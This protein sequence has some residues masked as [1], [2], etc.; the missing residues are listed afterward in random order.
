MI[1]VEIAPGVHESLRAMKD[2]GTPLPRCHKGVIQSAIGGAVRRLVDNT[3]SSGVRPWDVPELE[4]RTAELGELSSARAE[5]VDENVLVGSLLPGGQRI[6]LRGVDDEWR[7]VRFVDGDDVSLRPE[8][9]RRVELRGSAPDCV[10]TALG[11]VKPDRVE[12][13]VVSEYLGGGET[14]TRYRY[15]WTEGSKSILAEEVKNEIFDGATPYSTYVRGVIVD[16]DRGVLLTGR[17]DS[18]LIIEG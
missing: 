12:L 10:V 9:T 11:L 2:R 4:R 6:V 14:E 17:D 15:Q 16:G 7:L 3:L 5:S 8:T 18:A 13:E 1:P